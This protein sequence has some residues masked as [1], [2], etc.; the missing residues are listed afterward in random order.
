MK[1]VSDVLPD[2]QT[3]AI[4][5]SD[6]HGAGSTAEEGVS[7]GRDRVFTRRIRLA[8]MD[9][10]KHHA[11]IFRTPGASTSVGG[12]GGWWIV[13]NGS[14][15]GSFVMAARRRGDAESSRNDASIT[16]SD[17][18][19]AMY[20]RL[21]EP[22]VASRPYELRHGDLVR[23]GLTIF[24][25][26]THVSSFSRGAFG[27]DSSAGA[28]AA[29][30]CAKCQA[31]FDGQNLIPLL[32]PKGDPS[33]VST[34]GQG[35]E[36][37][38]GPNATGDVANATTTEGS[39]ASGSAR[40]LAGDRKLDSEAEWK[41]KMK[42]LKGAYLGGGKGAKASA[43]AAGG[44]NGGQKG[45]AADAATVSWKKHLSSKKKRAAADDGFMVSISTAHLHKSDPDIQPSHD[46][47]DDG[48]PAGAA[49]ASGSTSAEFSQ[50]PETADSQAISAAKYVDRAAQRRTHAHSIEKTLPRSAI[51]PDFSDG[52][53]GRRDSQ[54]GARSSASAALVPGAGAGWYGRS[55]EHPPLSSDP[56]AIRASAATPLAA[57]NRGFKLFSA[58]GGAGSSTD[59]ADSDGLSR[60]NQE[61]D[62]PGR[63]EGIGGRLHQDPILARGT[64][65]RAGLGSGGLRDVDEIANASSATSGA[66]GFGSYASNG[67]EAAWQRWQQSSQSRPS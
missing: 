43:N 6:D 60:G 5:D 55:S 63:T 25:V 33:G 2:P 9:V 35:A 18:P 50:V 44:A 40:P 59:A 22:K 65:G 1:L 19:L 27:D 21:S 12:D 15:H 32:A 53:I 46:P 10:S 16:I 57:S 41:R 47:N 7:I 23:I 52:S 30:C 26:H 29:A 20:H 13:D 17:P 34:E 58:I 61:E 8:S 38:S 39:Y 45:S 42:G 3:V 62:N 11:T 48:R 66:R 28:R 51:Q 54:N 37:S 36:T 24:V 64:S 67:R 56:P 4:I 31:D 49:S 14:A